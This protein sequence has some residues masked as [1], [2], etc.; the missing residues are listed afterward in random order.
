[1]SILPFSS[2]LSAEIYVIIVVHRASH[3]I[4][5]QRSYGLLRYHRVISSNVN[6]WI[7]TA[8]NWH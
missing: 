8:S 2:I 7:K 6:I 1:M 5:K 4:S 3:V